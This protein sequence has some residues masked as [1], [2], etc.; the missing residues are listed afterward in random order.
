[1]KKTISLFSLFMLLAT[2]FMPLVSFANEPWETVENVDDIL[3]DI[4]EFN[5]DPTVKPVDEPSVEPNDDSNIK[6]NEEPVVTPTDEVIDGENTEVKDIQ[7]AVSTDN[8]PAIT[9]E[10]NV[11]LPQTWFSE[12]KRRLYCF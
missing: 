9:E 7:D 11:E 10:N 2:N 4:W 12:Q 8:Q 5:G 3:T 6:E 1:M